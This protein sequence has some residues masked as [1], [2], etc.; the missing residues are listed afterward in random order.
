LASW[1]LS[2]SISIEGASREGV[3]G[4]LEDVVER[5]AWEGAGRFLDGGGLV[6]GPQDRGGRGGNDDGP[7]GA[8]GGKL[9]DDGGG[10]AVGGGLFDEARA[11]REAQSGGE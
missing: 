5:D 11:L 10:G 2:L 6:D 8:G 3:A 7:F 1:R 4:G 9:D